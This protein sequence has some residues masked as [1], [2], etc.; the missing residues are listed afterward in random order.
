MARPERFKSHRPVVVDRTDPAYRERHRELTR[1]IDEAKAG[2]RK[3]KAS[4]DYEDMADTSSAI[5][6]LM[7]QLAELEGDDN[8]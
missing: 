1:Q 3:A 2:Y 6:E 4:L 8:G 7:R 5:Y